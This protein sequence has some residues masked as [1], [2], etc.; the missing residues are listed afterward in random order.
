MVKPSLLVDRLQETGR[1]QKI[2]ISGTMVAPTFYFEILRWIY[3]SLVYPIGNWNHQSY[4]T[5]DEFWP[6][7]NRYILPGLQF[8]VSRH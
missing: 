3:V 8:S 2:F 5:W 4:P 1:V 6:T 7:K